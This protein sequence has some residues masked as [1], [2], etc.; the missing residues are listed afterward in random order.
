MDHAA[1]AVQ[2]MLK[3]L[4][5][6]RKVKR[7]LCGKAYFYRAA[8]SQSAIST[9]M[10]GDLIHRVFAGSADQL[11]LTLIENQREYGDR[12]RELTRQVVQPKR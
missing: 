7:T 4:E 12:I 8:V 3:I 11:I 5:R 9:A 6:K 2:T 10:L 1:R